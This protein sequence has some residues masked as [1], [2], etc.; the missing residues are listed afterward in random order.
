MQIASHS[1]AFARYLGADRDIERWQG[2]AFGADA[3]RRGDEPIAVGSGASQ[4]AHPNRRHRRDSDDVHCRG[5]A[6][7]RA[8]RQ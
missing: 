1:Q 4:L 3:N 6:Q 8:T 5:G 2:V 7:L